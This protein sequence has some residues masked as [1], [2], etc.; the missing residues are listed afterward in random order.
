MKRLKDKVAVITGAG[1]GIGRAIALLFAEEGAKVSIFDI[2]S[3]DG[4]ET[5]ALIKKRDKEAMFIKVDVSKEEEVKKAFKSV[6]EKY[7]KLDILCNNAGISYSSP[8]INTDEK[9]WDRVL[10]INLKGVFLCSKHAIPELIK[11]SG[12]IIN[13]SSIAGIIGLANETAYCASK[14]GVISLTKAMALELAPYK[15]RVNCICPGSTLTPMFENIL[16]STGDYEKALKANIERIPLK[17]IGKPEDI[18]YAALYLASEESSYVTGSVLVVD[19][20]WTAY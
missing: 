15:I 18:A 14:G 10:N 17:R 16:K 1:S 13:I 5:E 12:S 11:T 4:L 6:I 19:G 8:L 20:G 2:N 7:K 3:K 9:D